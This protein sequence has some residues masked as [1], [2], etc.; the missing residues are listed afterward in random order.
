MEEVSL[1]SKSEMVRQF[2]YNMKRMVE[3]V[4]MILLKNNKIL[5]GKIVNFSFNNIVFI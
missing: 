2:Q 4:L 1:E 3:K 5:M